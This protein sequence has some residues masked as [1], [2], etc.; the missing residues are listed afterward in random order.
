MK[1]KALV[2]VGVIL[3]LTVFTSVA[4][5][6]SYPAEAA[7]SYVAIIPKILHSGSTEAFSLSLLMKLKL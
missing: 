7:D 4:L 3:V 2:I 5:G 1:P 6:C